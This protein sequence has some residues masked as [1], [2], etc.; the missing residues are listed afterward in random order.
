[1]VSKKIL[2]APVRSRKQGARATPIE[3]SDLA[4]TRISKKD[5]LSKGTRAVQDTLTL[6]K[7][8]A[9]KS[10]K[11]AS[12]PKTGAR[13]LSVSEQAQEVR[14]K[15]TALLGNKIRV[16]QIYYEDWQEALLDPAFIPFNN[17]GVQMETMEFDVFERLAH[18]P[19][20]EGAALWGGLSWRYAEKTGMSG[21]GLIKLIETSPP[22]DVYYCNP[23]VH[24][25]A[26]FHNMWVQGETAHPQ[27]LELSA[28]LFSAAALDVQ[29]LRAI[30]A[31]SE[32]SAANYFVG[33]PVFW[34][35]Y[36]AFIRKTLAL[37]DAHMTEEMRIL[38][39]SS[40]ADNKGLHNGASYVP[41]IVERLFPI[42]MKTEGKT[43][44]PCKIDLPELEGKLNVH[45][46]LLREMKEMAHRTRSP[47]LAACWV[48]YRNLYLSQMY[49]K[50]WCQRY[51]HAITP[52]DIMFA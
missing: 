40:I 30:S 12:L 27:F 4:T 34:R 19:Y 7:V 1:M 52:A 39:Y 42:F 44:R 23:H 26:L 33:S 9:T 24:N 8:S 6:P 32:W 11:R 3:A 14:V 50:A 13:P 29:A 16:F 17:A 25:E 41:F 46:K 35:S 15:N 36:L 51:L 48:N 38:L 18:S 10:V 2:P 20:V 45:L 28:A 21:A 37:A 5:S 47:W 22:A 49:G 43:L 31:S